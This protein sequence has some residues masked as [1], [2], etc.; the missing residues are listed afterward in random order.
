VSAAAAAA[1]DSELRRIPDAGAKADPARV[2]IIA[3]HSS[4][5]TAPFIEAAQKLGIDVLIASEGEHSL[6][7]AF[8]QGLHVQLKNTE[9]ALDLILE[10]SRVRPFTGI[11][12]TDDSTTE[13]AALAAQHLGLPHNDPQAVRIA[14]R[15][16]LARARLFEAGVPV[17]WHL[18]IDLR[19]PLAPQLDGVRFPCVLK[20]VAL[21]ASRGVIRADDPDELFQAAARIRRIL[22]T[23]EHLADA[24]RRTLLVEDFVPGFEIAVEGMLTG[25]ELEILALFDK[26]D[27]LDGP[28]FEETYYTTPS[29]LDARTQEQIRLRVNEACAVYG[30]REG[31]V[32]AECRVNER[33]VWI[34]EVAARTI[35]GLCGR[36]LRFGTGYGLEELVLAHAMGRPLA[37]ERGEGAAGVLMIPVPQAGILR[38]VEGLSAAK[39]IPYIEEVHI[40]IREGYELV[41]WPEGSSYL[42]FIFARAPTPEEAEAA[43]RRSHA[44]LNVVVA[45]LWKAKVA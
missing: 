33:G 38:R 31:P 24:E 9:A 41:P 6:V 40:E 7:S 36:L 15:K 23:V 45:P 3:P 12:G 8:A 14:R 13:L 4:Y 17:P 39:D 10:E 37:P 18:C 25:G 22:E 43:L 35:G 32:H 27:P 34:I 20:P 16:D 29:R 28:F 2:L 26:P 42:G 5:R 11:V 1:A 44:C 19:Q 21:A 30:L